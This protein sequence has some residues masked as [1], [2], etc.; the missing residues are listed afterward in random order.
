MDSGQ[1]AKEIDAK[2]VLNNGFALAKSLSWL[3]M[4]TETRMQEKFEIYKKGGI[5]CPF[6]NCNPSKAKGI[7][8]FLF[9]NMRL[10]NIK[11]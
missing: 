11:F 5:F 3:A 9:T 10:F 6:P 8:H 4:H 2:R 7:F 1:S